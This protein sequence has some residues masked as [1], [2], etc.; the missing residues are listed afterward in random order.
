MARMDADGG[1]EAIL[2]S[3]TIRWPRLSMLRKFAAVVGGIGEVAV[4]GRVEW[5]TAEQDFANCSMRGQW[6]VG[7]PAYCWWC[8]GCEVIGGTIGQITTFA[9][10]TASYGLGRHFIW[11]AGWVWT[12]YRTPFLDDLGCLHFQQNNTT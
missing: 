1:R 12:L 11:L 2:R 4:L 9:Q 3:S 6:D 5:A 8:C 10:W 7:S